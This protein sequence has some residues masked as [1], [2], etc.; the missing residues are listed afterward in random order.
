M[1]YGGLR[2]DEPYYSLQLLYVLITCEYNY[3]LYIIMVSMFM[4]VSDIA[5]I[6]GK[7]LCSQLTNICFTTKKYLFTNNKFLFKMKIFISSCIGW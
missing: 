6:K 1:I 4:Y 5:P 3:K 2:S 7:V